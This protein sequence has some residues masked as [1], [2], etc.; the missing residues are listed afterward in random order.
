[1]G[2]SH[3]LLRHHQIVSLRPI[4]TFLTLN[5]SY[6]VLGWLNSSCTDCSD[7]SYTAHARHVLLLTSKLFHSSWSIRVFARDLRTI[8]F[9]PNHA[10][11]DAH[12]CI[13]I[14]HISVVKT[15]I[16][17]LLLSEL[18]VVHHWILTLISKSSAHHICLVRYV[19]LI[20][21]A[22][23]NVSTHND[24]V[25]FYYSDTANLVVACIWIIF[26]W[27]RILTTTCM[28]LLGLHNVASE[29]LGIF[30]FNLWVV[31]DIIVVI[32]V[33]YDF[34]R[35]LLALFL[36]FWWSATS[37]M[38]SCQWMT[39]IS[40]LETCWMSKATLCKVIRMGS[41]VIRI[42]VSLVSG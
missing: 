27:L 24:I 40:A 39:L 34:D 16:L 33:L 21:H 12:D 26:Y 11:A 42:L 13:L 5:G 10:S 7:G 18:T 36:W 20:H 23:S 4:D 29:H 32:Y 8:S 14:V 37:L 6:S 2:G 25:L 31:E 22:V 30:D 38:G 1:M 35:L 15:L 17:L 19:A 41:L 3:D 28:V 9:K